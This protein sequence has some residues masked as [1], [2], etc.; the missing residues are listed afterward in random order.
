L[1]ITIPHADG[2]L[3]LEPTSGN[4]YQVAVEPRNTSTFIAVRS[5]ETSYSP[6]LIERILAAKGLAYVCDELTREEYPL[7]V[8]LN[9]RYGILGFVPRQDLD[10]KRLLDFGSGAGSSSIVLARVLPHTQIVGVELEP[11]YV[12]LARER[13]AHRRLAIDF[14]VS[15]DPL[16]L[17]E[18]IGRCDAISFSAV[19]EHL[20]PAERPR[21]LGLLWSVL[22]P[23]GTLFIN[24]LPHR[25][26]PLEHHTTGLL[27]INYLPNRLA[28]AAARRWSARVSADESWTSLL[29][30][31]IRGG[32]QRG[33]L[34][35]LNTI[36]PGEVEIL[37]PRLP[38]VSDHADLWWRM[39][40]EKSCRPAKRVAWL[41]YKLGERITGQPVVQS[42]MLAFRKRPAG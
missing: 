6:E 19:Y 5:C 23:H 31:G 10:G 27:G 24:Q 38:N 25:Y 39:T 15:P 34:A 13:A 37:N 33:I 40:S 28:L 35:Y 30:R 7:Y 36:A 18:G 29:R 17:P 42:L 1:T 9:L 2:V 12:E 16:R 20:L 3:R 8:E 32:T 11:A 22:E 21:L 41:A 14:H 4:R 26:F